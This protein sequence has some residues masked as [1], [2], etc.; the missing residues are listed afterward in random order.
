M[1]QD[2]SAN[3]LISKKCSRN[4]KSVIS[5]RAYHFV[6]H[7]I[8][9]LPM[10]SKNWKTFCDLKPSWNWMEKAQFICQVISLEIDCIFVYVH[11]VVIIPDW[12][13]CR[14]PNSV[15]GVMNIMLQW[16]SKTCA[17][18]Q[19]DRYHTCM[20]Y[21]NI[22]VFLSKKTWCAIWNIYLCTSVYFSWKLVHY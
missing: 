18:E 13:T 11:S 5:G 6:V 12:Q 17:S 14:L 15:F 16:I 20:F 7:K 4:V 19:C 22:G 1:S 9:I 10:M 8:F 21:W 3:F 2:N